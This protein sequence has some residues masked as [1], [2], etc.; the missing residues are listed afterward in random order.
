M[1]DPTFFAGAHDFVVSGGTFSTQIIN[2]N[3]FAY[4][5]VNE[6]ARTNPIPAP[7]QLNSTLAMVAPYDSSSFSDIV[8]AIGIVQSIYTALSDSAG[9]SFE[10]TCLIN[11]LRSFGDALSLVN[12]ILQ[13]T[14]ISK[15]V[16]QDIE[17]ETAR[18]LRLLRKFWGHIKR[19]EVV[20]GGR[21]TVIWRKVTWA[22]WKDSE[23]KSFRRKLSYHER[24]IR[25][26]LGG[27][28]L[29]LIHAIQRQPPR[30]VGHDLENGLILID[31]LGSR[32]TLPMQFCFS[33]QELHITLTRLFNGKIGQDH[34]QRYDYSILTE[35][36]K[37]IAMPH[38]WG[39]IVKKGRVIVMSVIVKKVGLKQKHANRQRNACPRCY[40]TPIGVM[41]DDG[42]LQ[43][44]VIIIVLPTH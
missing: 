21:W 37:S 35:D 24:S 4:G 1:S 27:Q 40:E 2:Y 10:H 44:Y 41:P 36:G 31:A 26:F 38:N 22:I 39:A 5:E 9:S 32:I 33:E 8:T 12:S 6:G 16:R 20:P 13:T 3:T 19:Y 25:L 15:S 18:C 34:I 42:W 43:W 23:V 30:S 17:A 14:P 11:E 7:Q 29:A 28:D